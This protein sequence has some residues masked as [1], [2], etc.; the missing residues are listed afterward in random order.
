MFTGPTPLRASRGNRVLKGLR[1]FSVQLL[2]LGTV[3][4]SV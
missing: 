4:E 2:M 3:G 1:E